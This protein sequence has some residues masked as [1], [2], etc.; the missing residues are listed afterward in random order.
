MSK[1][2]ALLNVRNHKERDHKYWEKM[3]QKET[4]TVTSLRNFKE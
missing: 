2:T 1:D 4:F 3:F